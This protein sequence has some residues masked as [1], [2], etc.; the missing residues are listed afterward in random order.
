MTKKLTRIL[1]A[2]A[3]LIAITIF[4]FWYFNKSQE[5]VVSG[6]PEWPP[7]MYQDGNQIVGAGPEIVAKIFTELGVKSVSK[8]E[9]AWD[10]VQSKAKSGEVDVLVAAYKTAERETYMDYSIPYTVDPVVLIVKNGQT[11]AYAKNEDLIGKRG[12]VMLGDSYGQ[13]FD[14]FIKAKL[15]PQTVG[16]PKDAFDLLANGQA[17]YFVYALYSAQDYIF[18]N[19]LADQVEIL[20]EYVS[21]ENFYI[22]ISK[23]SPFVKL[24]P[25]VN[26]L[27]KK[28]IDDGTIDQIIEKH[29]QALWGESQ[30]AS[31]PPAQLANPASTNCAKV[32][33]NLVIQKRGDGGE[34]GLCYFE[35]NRACEEWALLR[36]DCPLGGRKTTGFDTID[37]NYCA[38]SGGETLAV[39]DSVCTFKDGSTCPTIDFYNGTCQAGQ[40]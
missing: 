8:Y 2:L 34:Y 15:T 5:L 24:L 21:S 33:G 39:P 25:K 9:G 29:K 32:G 28:Y 37:Q 18:K 1:I 36:G 23:K 10:V 31:N 14:D 20:P 17:D 16:T 4:G 6:H 12:V 38:W 30:T 3:F 26:E 27:L 11:F 40:N 7:I 35:D 19:K 13:K 22:T